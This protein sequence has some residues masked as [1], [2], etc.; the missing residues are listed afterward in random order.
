MK[1]SNTMEVKKVDDDPALTQMEARIVS[2]AL[3][4][5]GLRI[6]LRADRVRWRT[7][8]CEGEGQLVEQCWSSERN[9][10]IQGSRGVTVAGLLSDKSEA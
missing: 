10:R 7:G 2:L 8:R 3:C 5:D 9:E 4:T 1:P 6:R